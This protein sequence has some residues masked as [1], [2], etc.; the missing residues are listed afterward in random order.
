MVTCDVIA[1]G[2]A[3]NAVLINGNILLDCGVPFKSL[4]PYYKK[5]S[6]VLTTHAHSDHINRATVRRL[7]ADRPLLR[8]GGC[9]WMVLPLVDAGASVYKIDSYEI[10]K[11]YRYDIFGEKVF[12]EPFALFHD[13]PNCGYKITLPSGERV[14]YAT[15]TVSMDGIEAKD[16]DLYLIEANHG[17]NEIRKRIAEKEYDGKFSYEKRAVH[18]HLSKEQADDWLVRNMASY[19]EVV[20]LHGH[21]DRGKESEEAN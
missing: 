21:T 2:S 18:T 4:E 11:S 9:K 19:S 5:L 13:V 1:T 20:Y 12:V 3:G 7:A 8:F 17:E 16:Y 15:D 10:G 6:L 14:L